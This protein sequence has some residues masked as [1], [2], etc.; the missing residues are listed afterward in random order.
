MRYFWSFILGAF[1]GAAAFAAW[2]APTKIVEAPAAAARQADGSLALERTAT[3]PKAK[4]VAAIPK[5]GKAERAIR[6]DVQPERADCPICSVD[7]TLVR[8]PDDTRRVVA[9]SQ[10][11]TVL[12]GLDVPIE[13][14]A[15][16]IIVKNNAYSTLLAGITNV[17]TN[18]SVQSGH[19]ARFSAP[20]A[21]Q[22]AKIT[23]YDAAGNK[24]IV[25]C[26]ARTTD[27]FTI[28]RGQEGTT[29]RAWNAGDGFEERATSGFLAVLSQLDRTETHTAVKTFAG[30]IA[31]DT[32]FS[33]SPQIAG[34]VSVTG[35]PK[36]TAGI[37]STYTPN[38]G[39]TAA[40][41]TKALT[42]ALKT[43][44][45]A[46]PSAGSPVDIAFRNITVTTGNYVT[47]SIVAAASIVV[48]R[49]AALGFLAAR[50]GRGF[51]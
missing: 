25:H 14:M 3:N 44:A 38:I 34:G 37:G 36:F 28:A 20:G 2:Q 50:A 8:M 23:L 42:V 43:K 11:G 10:T 39:L 1:I 16:E 26:S 40:R 21:G 13:R 18:L 45:L 24:E 48:P 29:A 32:A 51:L 5:G 46:D 35:E 22:I 27:S 12:G 47:R 33:G 41:A 9:S 17:A 49:G 6:V 19:G 7:L 15:Q 4:P 30:G 31:G